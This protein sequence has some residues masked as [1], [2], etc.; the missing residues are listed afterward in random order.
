MTTTDAEGHFAFN[1]IRPADGVLYFSKPGFVD[2]S[3][4]IEW[5]GRT[6]ITHDKTLQ[7]NPYLSGRVETASYPRAWMDSVKVTWQPGQQYVLT[8]ETGSF[9]IEQPVQ[10]DGLL[11]FEKTGYRTSELFIKW[12]PQNE[13]EIALNANPTLNYF[14]L[15]T[16]VTNFY[17][18]RQPIHELVARARLDDA[19]DDIAG[20]Y[21]ECSALNIKKNLSYNILDKV[22]ERS[23]SERDLALGADFDM[24][25]VVGHDFDLVVVEES[26]Y[27]YVIAKTNL[28]RIIGDVIEIEA[29]KNG[30]DVGK[31][32]MLKWK[33]PQPGFNFTYHAKI[34]TDDDFTPELV[35]QQENISA[36][37]ESVFVDLDTETAYSW[38]IWCVDTFNNRARSRPVSFNV[39]E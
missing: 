4:R 38:E 24:R 10:V 17:E 29:P 21:I 3:S 28:A 23:F 12:P 5:N 9:H 14:T 25:Q 31:K 2:D 26:G 34:Y 22:F 15:N 7:K 8:D 1:K 18:P 6:S 13:I 11:T 39:K 35:W 30:E 20:V 32:F 27:D 16:I 33:N 37:V 36:D 19:E